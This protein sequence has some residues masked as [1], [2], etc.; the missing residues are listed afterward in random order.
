MRRFLIE[1][2]VGLIFPPESVGVQRTNSARPDLEYLI[3]IG[4]NFRRLN[5]TVV[6]SL[7]DAQFG[8]PRDGDCSS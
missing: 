7:E 1:L 5:R 8:F 4:D 3:G 2:V 6:F